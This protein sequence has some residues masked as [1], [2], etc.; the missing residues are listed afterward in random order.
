MD[1]L[2]QEFHRQL[3]KTDKKRPGLSFYTLRRT[4]R[5]VAD[6]VPDRVAIDLIMGHV[7]DSMGA[8]YRERIGDERLVAVTN[9]VRRWLFGDDVG[10]GPVELGHD[11]E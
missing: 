1:S 11:T 8:A 5:T 3:V 6:E 9:H 7:D 10:E 2:G 4:F